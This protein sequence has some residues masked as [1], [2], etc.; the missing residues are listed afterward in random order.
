MSFSLS[1]YTQIDIGWGFASDP[2]GGSLQRSPDPL[3]GFKG[4]ASQQEGNGGEMSKGL[5]RKW[6][7]SCPGCLS[8]D[9]NVSDCSGNMRRMS[10]SYQLQLRK[11]SV[12]G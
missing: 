3:A 2:T 8:C 9:Q 5:G 7:L 11:S 6:F 1:E 4:A 12:Y 10:T